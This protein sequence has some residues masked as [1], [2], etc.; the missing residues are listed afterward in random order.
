[1]QYGKNVALKEDFDSQEVRHARI[2]YFSEVDAWGLLNL[3]GG[4]F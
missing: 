3:G 2:F 1:M 4:T